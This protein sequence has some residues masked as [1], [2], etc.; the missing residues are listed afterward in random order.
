MPLVVRLRGRVEVPL[1][2]EA[3]KDVVQRHESLRTVYGERNG[4]GCQRILDPES[5][6]PDFRVIDLAN[7]N[8]DVIE[9][10]LAAEEKVAFHLREA[11]PFRVRLSEIAP[12]EYLLSLTIHHI[13]FDGWSYGVL[14]REL[15]VCYAARIGELELEPP[16]PR[17]RYVEFARWERLFMH[18]SLAQNQ[19]T[20]WKR[21]LSGM[22]R[23]Q[24]A[25]D[26]GTSIVEPRQGRYATIAIEPTVARKLAR[27]GS[28]TGFSPFTL[29]ATALALAIRVMTGKN[30]IAFGTIVTNRRYASF[31]E[32]IG[33]FVNAVVLRF[34]FADDDRLID[35]LRNS[36]LSIIEALDHQDFAF[37]RL[38]QEFA[39]TGDLSEF[40]L[41]QGFLVWQTAPSKALRIK[42]VDVSQHRQ[43]YEIA[44]ADFVLEMVES[45]DGVA[46]GIY[47]DANRFT[48]ELIES[49][50]RAFCSA[51]EGITSDTAAHIGSRWSESN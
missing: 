51:L 28:E 23:A 18:T 2:I 31:H 20:Y 22:A 35:V 30:D 50:V 1:L 38:V 29:T 36:R 39:R 9:R 17:F 13:A 40:A 42:G 12:S 14:F 11:P 34:M 44:R 41:V 33:F 26:L 16:R 46:A 4:L 43:G 19:L 27:A 5:S 8:R 47:Y 37:G 25:P 3:F 10:T 49:L 24:L 45:D 21:K 15:S 7:A 32:V 6:D 48:C